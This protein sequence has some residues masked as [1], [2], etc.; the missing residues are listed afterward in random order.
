MW[1][2]LAGL[3]LV[4]RLARELSRHQREY[5]GGHSGHSVH[6]IRSHH[7]GRGRRSMSGQE[8]PSRGEKLRGWI[9]V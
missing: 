8:R 5:A 3:V 7:S 6:S 4:L 2:G 1:G 9:G